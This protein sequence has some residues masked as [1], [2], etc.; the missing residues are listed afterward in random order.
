MKKF[1][2]VTII[3]FTLI[4]ANFIPSSSFAVPDLAKYEWPPNYNIGNF[5]KPLLGY[6]FSLVDD[7]TNNFEGFSFIKSTLD[8]RWCKNFK[9]PQCLKEVEAGANFA[10]NQVLPPCENSSQLISCIESVNLIYPGGSKEKLV[11]EKLIPGNTWPEETSPKVEAGSSASR[12]VRTLEKN[13]GK[14][15][16]V[17]VSG[18]VGLVSTSRTEF[19]AAFSAAVLATFQAAVEPYE[20]INGNFNPAMIYES[21][22]NRWFGTSAPNYCIWADK[23]E[24]GIQAEFPEGAKIELILHLPTEMSGWIIGRINQP[25]FSTQNLGPSKITGRNLSRVTLSGNP[26]DVPMFST[27]TDLENASTELNDYYQENGYCKK[28]LS[29]CSG[30][31]GR[32][33]ASSSFDLA[34]KNFKFFE[35]NFNNSANLVVP[36]WSFRS[37]PGL[38]QSYDRCQRSSQVQIN[39]IV[40]TNSSIYQGSPPSFENDTFIYKVAGLHLLPNKEVFQGSYDLVLK[41]EFARCLYGFSS[42]PIKAAVEVTNADGTNKFVTTSFTEK[43]GWM[44]LSVKGFTFS[45]PT[46][47][48]KLSQEKE[49]ETP[50]TTLDLTQKAAPTPAKALPRKLTITC[51]KGKTIKKVIGIKPSCPK[52]YKK[53]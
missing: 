17:T 5:G 20:K 2:S 21:N 16:K 6:S 38:N 45:Q 29:A 41:S 39:G 36:R 23:N 48:L 13:P 42:A 1:A 53:K 32:T 30:Y 31:F 19:S 43:D 22:G 35:K 34:Y 51:T 8:E 47:K 7:Y 33:V 9:D 46:I 49:V 24:C 10:V 52:G 25:I 12:W 40:T 18:N 15:F 26:V 4:F 27:K 28:S 3:V 44:Y 14:G 11:L 50:S 37:L